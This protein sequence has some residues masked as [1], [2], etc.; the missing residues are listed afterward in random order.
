M[1]WPRS[2]RIK[3]DK[4]RNN[5]WML[6][7]IYPSAS[8]LLLGVYFSP[9]RLY[10]T[11]QSSHLAITNKSFYSVLELHSCQL[12]FTLLTVHS[13]FAHWNVKSSPMKAHVPTCSCA[14]R[15]KR[16]SFIWRKVWPKCIYLFLGQFLF[17]NII[18][19]W[20]WNFT[21]SYWQILHCWTA[22][23]INEIWTILI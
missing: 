15:S 16:K 20:Y 21:L 11:R 8:P 19:N 2:R 12:F 3:R 10:V 23:N 18:Q 9:A 7:C 1:A 4:A 6:C 14:E 22:I 5:N 17:L 13:I